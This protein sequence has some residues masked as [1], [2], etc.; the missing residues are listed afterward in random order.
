MNTLRTS[1]LNIRSLWQRR[2]VK[3]EIDEELRFHLEQRTAENLTAGMSPEEATRE[4]HRW[5]ARL[6]TGSQPRA[7]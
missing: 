6:G 3:R 1:W 5:F 7:D 2:E 4:A